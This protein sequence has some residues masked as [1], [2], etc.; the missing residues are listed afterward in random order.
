MSYHIYNRHPDSNTDIEYDNLNEILDIIKQRLGSLI[1]PDIYENNKND[2]ISPHYQINKLSIIHKPAVFYLLMYLIR[3]LTHFYMRMLGFTYIIDVPTQ[4]RVWIKTNKGAVNKTP[5]VF[6]HG[7][8]FGIVLYLFKI[9][10][11]SADRETVIIPELPN[12]SYDLYKF[13]PVPIETIVSA[14]YDILVTKNIK[15]V[16]I[17]GHSYGGII[18]NI[19]QIK[20]PHMCN[21]KTY[22]ENGCF[23]IHAT[24]FIDKM[25]R[26]NILN[27][28]RTILLYNDIYIQFIINRCTFVE[29]TLI[30]NLDDKTTII[31]AKDDELIPS[32]HI[33][34]YITTHYPQVRVEIVDGK[35]GTYIFG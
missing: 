28:I 1:Q 10:M 22:I 2:I 24:H 29:N 20:Y 27:Y 30:K 12:I 11:L 15:L 17:I 33:H 8:G 25:P 5:L 32:Y 26:D 19:F 31:L 14:F 34:K 16:D 13:P 7:L 6:I 23:Y 4:L 18:L 35:H 21:Y 3:R 9:P